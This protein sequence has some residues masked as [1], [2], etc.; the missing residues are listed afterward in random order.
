MLFTVTNNGSGVRAIY[1]SGARPVTV[2]PGD[3]VEVEMSLDE[4]ANGATDS[5]TITDPDGNPVAPY[6]EAK[7]PFFGYR[8][9]V[10]EVAGEVLVGGPGVALPPIDPDNP[11]YGIGP[12]NP[13]DHDHNGSSGGSIDELDQMKV[14]DLKALAEAEGADLQDATK[15]ADIIAA[16]R[17]DREAK[18]SG[19]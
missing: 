14:A 15:K 2:N 11:D 13:L 9:G 5:V 10:S 16:I 7:A 6:V 4:A 19:Q 12:A 8:P 3:T 1:R 18:A 17:L